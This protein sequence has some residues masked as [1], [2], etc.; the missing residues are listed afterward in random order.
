[1][2]PNSSNICKIWG[3]WNYHT[4]PIVELPLAGRGSASVPQPFALLY[5]FAASFSILSNNMKICNT[6]RQLLVP[7]SSTINNPELGTVPVEL[8]YWKCPWPR[9]AVLQCPGIFYFPGT[10]MSTFV[11]FS[12]N[13][14]YQI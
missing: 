11:T 9:G 14:W 12:C 1:M 3:K 10:D 4:I 13:F 8:P 2:V 5:A 7:N 6:L